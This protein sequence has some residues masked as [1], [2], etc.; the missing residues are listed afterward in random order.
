MHEGPYV[1]YTDPAQENTR[2]ESYLL[3]E[4]GSGSWVLFVFCCFPFW[5]LS[6]C[7][8]IY[9]S[10]SHAC[11][12]QASQSTRVQGVGVW[13]ARALLGLAEFDRGYDVRFAGIEKDQASTSFLVLRAL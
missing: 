8:R 12:F 11:S 9:T 7:V 10:R 3:T 1:K 5:L 6:S 13:I 2:W 4:V